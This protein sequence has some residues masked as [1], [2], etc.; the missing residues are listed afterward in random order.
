[1]VY[2]AALLPRE[3]SAIRFG[4]IVKSPAS[5]SRMNCVSPRTGLTPQPLTIML[6]QTM[7]EF[8]GIGA[9]AA[10]NAAAA[11]SAPSS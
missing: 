6:S 7:P 2:S 3:L 4:R 1:M 8:S 11:K 10:D 5:R 9:A